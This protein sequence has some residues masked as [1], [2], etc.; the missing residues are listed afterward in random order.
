[1]FT[2]CCLHIC[3]GSV[4]PPEGVFVRKWE[5]CSGKGIRYKNL[6]QIEYADSSSV[7]AGSG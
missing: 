1:M 7:D 2:I 6:C 5:G 3:I 4:K